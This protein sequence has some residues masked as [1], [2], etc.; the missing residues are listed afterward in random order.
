M[1]ETL[2]EDK[3]KLGELKPS[4]GYQFIYTYDFGDYWQHLVEVEAVLPYEPGKFYPVCIKAKRACPPED[5]G[6]V[7]GYADFLEALADKNHEDHEM[8]VEWSGGEFDPEQVDLD[9]INEWLDDEFYGRRWTLR[10]LKV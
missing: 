1:G 8:M 7:W 10:K 3:V 4:V 5:V 9:F 6:G 2:S